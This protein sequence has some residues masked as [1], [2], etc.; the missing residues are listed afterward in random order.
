MKD[1]LA[2]VMAGGRGKRLMPL[3]KDRTKPAVP[4]GGIYRLIDFTLSNC[5]NSL[6]YKIIVL[7]QYKSQS[8]VD[9]L[10]AG[11]RIFSEKIGHFLKVVPP[12]QRIGLDW[13]RGT[14]DSIRQNLYLIERYKPSHVLI[15]SGDH[16]YKMDYRLFFNYHEEKEADVTI[17]LLE[18]DKNVAHQFGVAEV[19]SDFRI[20][21]FQEKPKKDPKSIPG[22][23]DHVLASMGIYL[24]RT[25]T[26]IKMLQSSDDDFGSQLIP[27]SLDTYRVYA[28][29]YRQHNRI[30]DYIY[31]TLADGERQLQ[32]EPCTRDSGYWRDVGTLDSYWNANMDLTG[33]DPYFN[34]YGVKW[35]IHTYQFAAPPA[36]FIFAD[37]RHEDARVG[38]A[39]ESLVAPGCIVSGIVRNS[40]LS[41]NVIVR[42]WSTVEESVIM[43]GV[44][45][46]RHSK[47]KKTIVDMNNIIPPG[48][49][50]GYN[51]EEDRKRFTVTSRGIVVVPKG[52]FRG[53]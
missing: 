30:V 18:A 15:L 2:F 47:I 13:Y 20:L 4:F 5:V 26:L 14:A 21:G 23:P 39:L 38:K 3:T 33:V 42:S 19:D 43:A 52:Y 35:P 10:D 29:P 34:L 50:I 27:H 49:Q 46:G 48:T 28:Y 11:W 16:I 37:E 8:L 9:H 24:F 41:Y 40:I 1:T 6:I 7:P 51:P 22:D 53:D 32:L 31:V 45:V 36:K 12:Q 44:T 25:E 17:S